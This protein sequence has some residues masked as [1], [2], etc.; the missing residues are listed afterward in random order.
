[1][2]AESLTTWCL[3]LWSK[4]WS[5]QS[6]GE[7]RG[8]SAITCIKGLVIWW[9]VAGMLFNCGRDERT[10]NINEMSSVSQP[11]TLLCSQPFSICFAEKCMGSGICVC[12]LRWEESF[13]PL[14]VGIV[15][16]RQDPLGEVVNPQ[17]ADQKAKP[18]VHCSQ[19]QRKIP[20]F[21]FF[22]I[23]RWVNRFFKTFYLEIIID[24]QV[25]SE[26][27]QRSPV[28]PSPISPLGCIFGNHTTISKPGNWDWYKWCV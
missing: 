2:S 17:N 12:E 5:S 3:V 1:M 19:G 8:F 10:G 26:I 27:I 14:A 16:E 4:V 6:H 13:L 9:A 21:I 7:L 22:K 15:K 11:L 20:I 18:A 24:T 23:E 28:Y 25:V